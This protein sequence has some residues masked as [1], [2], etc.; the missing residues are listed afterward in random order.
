[1]SEVNE[2]VELSQSVNDRGIEAQTLTL[3]AYVSA[4]LGDRARLNRSL[5]ALSDLSEVRQHLNL[6]WVSRHG[7]AMLAILDGNF[8][9]AENLARDSLGF[10]RLAFGGQVE[11]VYGIQ[12]FSIRREQGRLAEVAPT[13]LATAPCRSRRRTRA[14]CC[15]SRR[16]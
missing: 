13:A 11:G 5:A 15:P 16:Q 12:M 8:A 3:D 4:E 14:A 1:L 10:G 6:Q 9:H 2:L 7:A